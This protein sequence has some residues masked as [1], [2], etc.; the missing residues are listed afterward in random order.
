M[1]VTT[2]TLAKRSSHHLNDIRR[3]LSAVSGTAN[4]FQRVLVIRDSL[5]IKKLSQG[6]YPER[7]SS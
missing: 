1:H 4:V 5:F 7:S 2:S 3:K 6:Y